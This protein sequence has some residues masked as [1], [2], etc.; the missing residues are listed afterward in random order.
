MAPWVPAVLLL[1]L[2]AAASGGQQDAEAM[3]QSGHGPFKKPLE[4][5]MDSRAQGEAHDCFYV[6]GMPRTSVSARFDV[7]CARFRLR[8]SE[9]PL[10]SIESPRSKFSWAVICDLLGLVVILLCIPLLLSCSKR[11]RH[12]THHVYPT[13]TWLYIG[14]QRLFHICAIESP[15]E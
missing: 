5:L 2:S 6:L 13:A 9:N 1:A 12:L 11:R 10:K 8:T 14:I 15:Q 4:A 7:K 3:P